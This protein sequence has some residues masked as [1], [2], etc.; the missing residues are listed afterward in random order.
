MT[1]AGTGERVSELRIDT[2]TGKTADD[3][4]ATRRPFEHAS[5]M[6]GRFYWREEVLAAE[7]ERIFGRLWL[8]AGRA[9]EL[10]E[11]GSFVLREVG[12]ESIVLVR[13]RDGAARAFFNVCRHRGTR[14]VSAECGTQKNFQCP[15]HAWTYSLEG[16]LIGAPLM[17]STP[18]FRRGD[19]PLVQ[20]QLETWG[21][22]LFINLD[23]QAR[24]LAHQLHDLPDLSR[25]GLDD[26][27]TADRIRYDV[28]AN[29]K[30]LSENYG[31]CYHCALVHPQLHRISHYR[32]G[33]EQ[34]A[35]AGYVGG[36]MRLNPGFNTMSHSGTTDRPSLPGL[37]PEDEEAVYYYNVFPNLLLS[38]HRDYVL[39]HTLWP[40]SPTRTRIDCQWLFHP[41]VMA[42][43]DFDPSD[44]VEFWDQTNRQD[45]AI[46][47]RSQLG[48]RSR[49]YRPSRFQGGE[50]C[51]HAFDLWYLGTMG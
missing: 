33:G 42:S 40:V 49:G 46:V 44:A 9:D 6:A 25:F 48:V 45:W 1:P 16:D 39:V 23:E 43:E 5:P 47:E 4:A 2:D 32:S 20:V 12:D 8:C 31:E 27:R 30:L 3:T 35:S 15:Y 7:M 18:G 36:P 17:D 10:A 34:H 38:L 14:L 41:E 28:A 22:L 11:P 24:P 26:L 51:V 19:F 29:W 13:G 50:G 37:L 21:G